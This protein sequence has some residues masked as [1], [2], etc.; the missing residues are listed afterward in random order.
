[1]VTLD[2]L[3][4]KVI[5]RVV[6]INKKATLVCSAAGSRLNRALG[7]WQPLLQLHT[8]DVSGKVLLA[9]QREPQ[10]HCSH[11]ASTECFF[12]KFKDGGN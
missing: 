6:A 9:Q 1:M 3:D 5:D 4:L 2:F 10:I 7:S 11:S 8:T 12:S